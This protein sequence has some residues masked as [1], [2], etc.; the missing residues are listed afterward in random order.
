MHDPKIQRWVQLGW[1]RPL[2]AEELAQV[3]KIIASDPQARAMWENESALNHC[4]DR[5]GPAVVSSNFTARVLQEV[6]RQS[7]AR[8]RSRFLP[9]HWIPTGWLPRLAV[10]AL[11]VCVGCV[12]VREYQI[13]QR[14]RAARDMAA[15]SRLATLPPVDW[16]KNFDTIDKLSKVKVADEDLL[17]VL[18]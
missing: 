4:L 16:L 7:L 17:S 18:R 5:L 9:S 6:Q 14:Q 2:R 11:M 3:E 8:S 13:V 10:G 12:S 15:L 1:R